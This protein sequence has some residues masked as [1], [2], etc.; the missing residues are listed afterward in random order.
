MARVQ[1]RTMGTPA[2]GF[3]AYLPT[4]VENPASYG[5]G[6]NVVEAYLGNVPIASPRPASTTDLSWGGKWQPSAVAPNVIQPVTYVAK[7]NQA[8]VMIKRRFTDRPMPVPAV[9]YN[10]T[11]S[12]TSLKA[13]IGG[14]VATPA[15]RPYTAWPTY[16]SH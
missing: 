14:R 1:I 9:A 6:A 13:R 10:A 2:S 16:G 11:T 4:M 5:A 12:A 3:T 7:M 8:L 15:V